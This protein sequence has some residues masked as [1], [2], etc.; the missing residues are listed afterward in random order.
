MRLGKISA[1][2][3]F[4]LDAGLDLVR[5][6]PR[7]RDGANHQHPNRPVVLDDVLAIE[8]IGP[9]HPDQNAIS[10]SEMIRD[11][12]LGSELRQATARRTT[13]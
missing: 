9:E 2:S 8:L 11:I 1:R 7:R 13:G 10:W 6:Q 3:Q 4:F 5:G 12:G